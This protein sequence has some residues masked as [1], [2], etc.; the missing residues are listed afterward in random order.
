MSAHKQCLRGEKK[1][2][3]KKEEKKQNK[4]QNK[5]VN[6]FFSLY[7]AG[8][9]GVFIEWTCKRDRTPWLNKQ[10]MKE[11]KKVRKEGRKEGHIEKRN[12][13]LPVYSVGEFIRSK[14]RSLYLFFVF[15]Y[16]C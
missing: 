12:W 5:T 11:R 2:K 15:V 16:P 1:K 14:I 9:T 10:R 3:R 8:F 4:K 6:H 13:I 7:E